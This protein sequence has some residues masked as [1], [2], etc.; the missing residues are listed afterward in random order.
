M[1]S[2]KTTVTLVGILSK[3]AISHDPTQSASFK[4]QIAANSNPLPQLLL[5]GDD[6]PEKETLEHELRALITRVSYLESKAATTSVFPP[7]ASK[8][9]HDQLKLTDLVVDTPRPASPSSPRRVSTGKES[10]TQWMNEW[11]AKDALVGVPLSLQVT[12]EQLGYIKDHL[13]KQANQ[14]RT[15]REQ[16][17]VLSAQIS[18]QK[19]VQQSSFEH[20]LEDIGALKRELVKHQQAN[21]AFQKALREIGTIITAVANGDLGQK[22][23]I[24]AKE[25]DPEIATFKR[26]TNRMI[27]QLQEF[28]SQVTKLAREVG[29]EGQLGGQAYVPDVK[30]V[31]AELTDNG[32]SGSRVIKKNILTGDSEPD[33]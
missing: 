27:D 18:T 11:L 33:G 20:S 19:Q 3:I 25:L 5:S 31:W 10:G 12:E 14:L 24:H 30:G 7:T 23:L 6:S 15:Q 26:T 1:L 22:V 8:P 16:I 9:A 32:G 17:N 4:P 21:L 29:T 2:S 28:A 13:N